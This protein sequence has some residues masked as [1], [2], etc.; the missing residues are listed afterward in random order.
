MLRMGTQ[1]RKPRFMLRPPV[2][3]PPHEHEHETDLPQASPQAE[4]G[5]E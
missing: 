5:N 1:A 3:R 4:L 2:Q